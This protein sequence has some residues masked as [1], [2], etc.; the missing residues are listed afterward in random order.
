MLPWLLAALVLALGAIYYAWRQ[1]SRA[2]YAGVGELERFVPAEPP[3]RPEPLSRA[4]VPTEPAAPPPP[5]PAPMGVVSTRLRPWLDLDFQPGRCVIT[6]DQATIEFSLSVLNSGSSPAR[7][8]LIEACMFNAGPV[9][10]QQIAA[11]FENPVAKGERLPQI[12]PLKKVTLKSAVT[13]PRDQVVEFEVA[14]RKLFVPLI[15]FSALYRWGSGEGQTSMSYLTGLD[16]KSEKMGPFRLDLGPRIFRTLA[17]REHHVR[18]R[19]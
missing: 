1:R 19:N 18:V 16:T 6:D 13:L 8:V 11:F 5:P 14:G 17:A 7:D 9:Q 12:P 10:D 4:P 2:Y 15:G 3:V